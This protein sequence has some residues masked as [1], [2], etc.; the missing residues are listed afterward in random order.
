MADGCLRQVSLYEQQSYIMQ[1]CGSV[2]FDHDL[3]VQRCFGMHNT[4]KGPYQGLSQGNNYHP[5]NEPCPENEGDADDV[6]ELLVPN[7]PE[8]QEQPC[9]SSCSPSRLLFN[10]LA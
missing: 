4:S 8:Q 3:T 9:S 7:T 5:I 1:T 6:R 10:L 2:R